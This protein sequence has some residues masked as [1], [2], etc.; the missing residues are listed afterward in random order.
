MRIKEKTC[1]RAVSVNETCYE[2]NYN[3]NTMLQTT[4]D[5][6]NMTWREFTPAEEFEMSFGVYGHY[7]KYDQNG[8]YIYFPPYQTSLK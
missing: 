3:S 1:V 6:V 7:G 2:I 5:T 4:I 8:Y